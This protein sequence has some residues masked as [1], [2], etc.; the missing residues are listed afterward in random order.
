MKKKTAD[1][2]GFLLLIF[3]STH[4]VAHPL[5]ADEM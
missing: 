3:A 1:I 2:G 5:T 4:R